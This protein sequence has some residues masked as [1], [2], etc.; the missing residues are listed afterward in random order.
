VAPPGLPADRLAILRSA[1]APTVNDKGFLA[2]AEKIRFTIGPM[3]ADE[4]AQITHETIHAP[5]DI[6]DK[7]KTA[8][9]MAER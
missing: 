6:V 3:S 2:E 4:V 7:A 5:P 9:G 8:M 1:F